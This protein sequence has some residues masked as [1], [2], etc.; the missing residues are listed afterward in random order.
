MIWFNVLLHDRTD[1]DINRYKSIYIEKNRYTW[2]QTDMQRYILSGLDSNYF[3]EGC[4]R[5]IVKDM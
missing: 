5:R 4:I 2:I 3:T 1:M